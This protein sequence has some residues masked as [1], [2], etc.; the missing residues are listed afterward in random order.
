MSDFLAALSKVIDPELRQDIVSLG[1]V[2]EILETETEVSVEL[3]LTI[4]GC[5]AAQKIERDV[6]EAIH[7]DKKV[8]VKVGVMTQTERDALKE[9]LR[10]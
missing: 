10:G 5:P 9:K 8:S 2:G 1:M 3:K 6:F 7:T 4:A